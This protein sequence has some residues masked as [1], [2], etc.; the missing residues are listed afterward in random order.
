MAAFLLCPHMEGEERNV[1]LSSHS[2]KDTNT[3][4]G[5]LTLL[6]SSKPNYFPKILLPNAIILGVRDSKFAVWVGVHKHSIHNQ[7]L[8]LSQR[9]GD[10]WGRSWAHKEMFQASQRTI[11]EGLEMHLKGFILTAMRIHWR[12]LNPSS[13]GNSNPHSNA[14]PDQILFKRTILSVVLKMN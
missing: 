10:G 8:P 7:W 13:N 2:W 12:V 3:L 11:S 6:T 9:K 1:G 5:A 14:N 4:M